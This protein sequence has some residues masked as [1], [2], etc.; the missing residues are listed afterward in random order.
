MAVISRLEP[1]LGPKH[2]ALVLFD[3]LNAFV[4]PKDP[5]RRRLLADRNILPNLKRLLA[6]ARKVGMTTIYPTVG[7]APDGSDIVARL[8]DTAMDLTPYRERSPKEQGTHVPRGTKAAEIAPEF[9]PLKTDVV[10]PKHKWNAFF[11]TDLDF[12]LR[13]RGIDTIVLAGGSTDVGIAATAYGA[14]DLDL[15]LVIAH[16]ACHSMIQENHD[17]LMERVFPRMGR[18]MSVD[19]AVGLMKAGAKKK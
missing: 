4:H 14:R 19:D 10:V 13:C 3:C 15:G 1:T 16:D 9:K 18:V 8:T 6:G 17:F 12:H 11:M 7:Y 2:T 5:K